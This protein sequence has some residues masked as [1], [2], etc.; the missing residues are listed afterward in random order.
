MRI[1]TLLSLSKQ[2]RVCIYQGLATRNRVDTILGHF[3]LMRLDAHDSLTENDQECYPHS[4]TCSH[5]PRFIFLLYLR[6]CTPSSLLKS[7]GARHPLLAALALTR[8]LFLFL[9]LLALILCLLFVLSLSLLLSL[10][11]S[12]SLLLAHTTSLKHQGRKVQPQHATRNTQRQGSLIL[13]YLLHLLTHTRSS[14]LPEGL[15]FNCSI[16][17]SVCT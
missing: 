4:F 3:P 2:K 5:T 8:A 12:L 11:L 13:V 6:H 9:L 17:K 1:L 7:L 15:G 10:S 16:L 14:C